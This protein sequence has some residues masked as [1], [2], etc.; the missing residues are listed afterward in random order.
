MRRGN[1]RM[2]KRKVF[3]GTLSNSFASVDLPS[4]AWDSRLSWDTSKL[5]SQGVLS[6]SIP[7][8]YAVSLLTACGLAMAGQRRRRPLAK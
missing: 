4:L 6:V 3:A 2:Q 7:E 1:G 8:P 5:D